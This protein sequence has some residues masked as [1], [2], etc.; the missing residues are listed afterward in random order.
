MLALVHW[1]R[2]TSDTLCMPFVHI[3]ARFHIHPNILTILSCLSGLLAVYYFQ[4]LSF[5]L[6]FG[7]FHLVFDKLDGVL[8][9]TTK[10]A[11]VK[12]QWLDHCSD[13]IVEAALL[14]QLAPLVLYGWWV[15]SFYIVYNFLYPF[16]HKE[17]YFAR[18][19]LF[20]LVPFQFYTL[21]FAIAT[22]SYL[23]GFSIQIRTLFP[24][25]TSLTR[26]R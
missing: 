22:C 17:L 14:V 16:T 1:V 21:A 25:R 2:K 3:L 10:Q 15:V 13:R 8:A 5:F 24:F 6:L 19:I 7:I 12:G 26:R 20:I 11:T 23:I 4:H 9:R 18:T